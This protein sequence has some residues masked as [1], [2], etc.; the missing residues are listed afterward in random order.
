MNAVDESHPYT[1]IDVYV[2]TTPSVSLKNSIL[3][4]LTK[5]WVHVA[6]NPYTGDLDYIT[7]RQNGVVTNSTSNNAIR[8][9]GP[10]NFY[11]TNV[12]NTNVYN[13]NVYTLPITPIEITDIKVKAR[14]AS[15]AEYEDRLHIQDI[16]ECNIDEL[17]F[18]LIV[19]EEYADAS[20]QRQILQSFDFDTCKVGITMDGFNLAYKTDTLEL[21][22]EKELVLAEDVEIN[23]KIKKRIEKYVAK[24]YNL[25]SGILAKLEAYNNTHNIHNTHN[26]NSMAVNQ[27]ANLFRIGVSTMNGDR[28]TISMVNPCVEIEIPPP[29][30]RIAMYSIPNTEFIDRLDT[31]SD[32]IRANAGSMINSS[33]WSYIDSY[34]DI[35][36]A[37]RPFA[38]QAPAIN[39]QTERSPW[40]AILNN[41]AT[42]Q[43]VFEA[44][45]SPPI[46]RFSSL[47]GCEWCNNGLPPPPATPSGRVE[48]IGDDSYLG[49]TSNNSLNNS[50]NATMSRRARNR[51][52][53]D[54]DE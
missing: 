9:A 28:N 53:S 14:N 52:S 21:I 19:V 2:R 50:L 43:E 30:E 42:P 6:A 3:L 10:P 25:S 26:T 48:D 23:E 34:T 45:S 44:Y 36:P 51:S 16:I 15:I 24:G 22:L 4:Q 20:F 1:D 39:E 49:N 27:I 8:V 35:S 31:L 41:R 47:C 12:Y 13:A 11:N 32:E 54:I 40:R 17:K 7:A 33:N 18:Q 5:K 46:D 37:A 38:E 29:A